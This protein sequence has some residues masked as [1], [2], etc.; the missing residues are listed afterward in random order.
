MINLSFYGGIGE[1]GGNK[2]LLDDGKTKIFLDFGKSFCAG[3]DYFID[4][5][6]PRGVNGIGDYLEF[7]LLP[8]LHGL[9]SKEL[10]QNTSI[11]YQYPMYDGVFISHVHIDHI[12]D[13]E[14]IDKDI[15]VYCGETTKLITEAIEE[16]GNM[17][18]GEHKYSTFRTGKK[19]K[20]GK[21]VIE[22]VHVDHSV[23]GAYGFVIYTAG[24]NI[25][26]RG[27]GNA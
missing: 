20:I 12:G 1:I 15:P 5:L 14:F 22:P 11:K 25:V 9:Y 7:N 8:S 4:Y 3:G 2:V 17:N 16:S 19:I 26:Y 23:P 10:L 24:G 6:Q 13:I 21:I 18:Y 27:R